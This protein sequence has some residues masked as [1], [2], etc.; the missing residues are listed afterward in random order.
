MTGSH[1]GTTEGSC[2]YAREPAYSGGTRESLAKI[3]LLS[4]GASFP[5]KSENMTVIALSYS[6]G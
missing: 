1:S 3:F 2:W 5:P 4:V 6:E